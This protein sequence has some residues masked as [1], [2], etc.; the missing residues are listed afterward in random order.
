MII[1]NLDIIITK[2]ADGDFSTIEKDIFELFSEI[3]SGALINE[4]L[5]LEILTIVETCLRMKNYM[6]LVDII[7]F[8]LK[9]LIKDILN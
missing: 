5:Y 2:I 9:P 6:Y 8:E 7:Q 1:E 3:Y 4:S